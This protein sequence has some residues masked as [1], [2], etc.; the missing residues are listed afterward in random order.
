[1]WLWWRGGCCEPRSGV[2][3]IN[4][5]RATPCNQWIRCHVVQ[6]NNDH[7][8]D[9]R[10]LVC[11]ICCKHMAEQLVLLHGPEIYLDDICKRSLHLVQMH[12][13]LPVAAVIRSHLSLFPEA[14][15]RRFATLHAFLYRTQSASSLVHF[16]LHS[17]CRQVCLQATGSADS[18][19]LLHRPLG[20]FPVWREATAS[21]T[22]SRTCSFS[23]RYASA[24]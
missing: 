16:H 17:T 6:C 9:V 1:M 7:L 10:Y 23:S 13:E 14:L 15:I 18:N 19:R 11:E 22:L 20:R 3:D 21:S 12:L 24:E 8:L 5:S 4:G 2:S